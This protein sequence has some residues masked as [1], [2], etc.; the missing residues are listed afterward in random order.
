MS[1]WMVMCGLLALSLT[2]SA[3]AEI[4]TPPQPTPELLN[5]RGISE[6]LARDM[7]G[8]ESSFLS[9]LTLRRG[10]ARANNNLG[11]LSLLKGDLTVALSFYDHALAADTS[12]YGVR[13]NRA[14][15][16]LLLG[17]EERAVSEAGFVVQAA[18]GP[19]QAGEKLGLRATAADSTRAAG[20]KGLTKA[21]LRELL[22][23]ASKSVP[24]TTSRPKTE[25]APEAGQGRRS[26]NWRAGATRAADDSESAALLYWKR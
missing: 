5:E 15:A 23:K 14:T 9:V 17:D 18:G 20:K 19:E 26:P 12:D 25:S 1:R 7:D 16:Y 4:S 2:G 22:N 6:A 13:M 10:D 3:A 24:K 21:E 11:N 8:A